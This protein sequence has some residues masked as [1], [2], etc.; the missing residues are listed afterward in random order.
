MHCIDVILIKKSELRDLKISSLLEEGSYKEIEAVEL[1]QNLLA[2]PKLTPKKVSSMFGKGINFVWVNT[3]YF[4]GSG[5]QSA[6]LATSTERGNKVILSSNQYNA[7]NTIL[8]EYGVVRNSG[9][10][11]FDSINLGQYRSN[12][13]FFLLLK[14]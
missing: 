4:G 2:F 5:E 9:L 8:K 7:I 11:E 10:D 14:N 6:Y 1:P 13:D 12:I 3:D